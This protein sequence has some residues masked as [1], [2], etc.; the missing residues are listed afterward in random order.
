MYQKYER[1]LIPSML[2]LGFIPDYVTFKTI[3]PQTALTVLG[4]YFA[5]VGIAIAFTQYYDSGRITHKLKFVRLFTPLLVQFLFGALLGAV[6]VFYWFSASIAASWLFIILI[7]GLIVSNELLKHHLSKPIIQASVYYFIMFAYLSIVIPY[8]FN[9]IGPRLFLLSGVCSLALMLGY[10]YVLVLARGQVR[11]QWRSLAKIVVAIFVLMNALYFADIVPPIP[12]ALRQIGV[13]HNIRPTNGAYVL[14]QE[15]QTIWQKILPGTV[16]HQTNREPVYVY[17][18]I[19]APNDL[20]TKIVHV[21]QKYV[22]EIG[23]VDKDTLSFNITGGRK[24]GFRGYSVKRAVD[25][26]K[27]RV[28]VETETGQKLG[29]VTF[30]VKNGEYETEVGR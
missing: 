26:G 19:F 12:L 2:V 24:E 6:F 29:R 21:W 8:A 16:I 14:T 9:G 22:D 18:A 17:S 13:Y 1:V 4:C 15:K 3:K 20:R 11:A 25:E 23:W 30:E 27:W 10:I 5:M 7:L 28:W